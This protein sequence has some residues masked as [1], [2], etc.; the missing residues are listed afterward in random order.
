VQ[1]G[2]LL[3]GHSSVPMN[4][5]IAKELELVGTFISHEE[6]RWGVDALVHRRIDIGPILSGEFSFADAISAFELT[7][8]RRGDAREFSCLRRPRTEG[9]SARQH[10]DNQKWQ[11]YRGTN[12]IVIFFGNPSIV[13]DA[14]SRLSDTNR[15]AT[16]RRCSAHSRCGHDLLRS[17]RELSFGA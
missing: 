3:G 9:W 1:V 4:R 2:I 12:T 10:C 17:W 13:S 14:I 7:S 6:F 11:Y 16:A 15:R 5:V 8:D